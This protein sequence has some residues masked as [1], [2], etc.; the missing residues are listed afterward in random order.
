MVAR[1]LFLITIISL[2][3]A[4]NKHE[5]GA[6]KK[7]IASFAKSLWYH[8]WPRHT[9][10]HISRV[11]VRASWRSTLVVK[12]LPPGSNLHQNRCNP[13]TYYTAMVTGFGYTTPPKPQKDLNGTIK[14]LSKRSLSKIVEFPLLQTPEIFC[15]HQIHFTVNILKLNIWIKKPELETGR[16]I[17]S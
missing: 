1:H 5:R 13:F 12:Q 6:D 7:K 8:T 15:S 10:Y 17:V 2:H 14:H 9:W 3:R 16:I 11:V 4:T